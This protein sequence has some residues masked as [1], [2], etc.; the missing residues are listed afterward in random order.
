M[1]LKRKLE[2]MFDKLSANEQQLGHVVSVCILV[3]F[4][5]SHR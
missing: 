4:G 2:R 3:V 5:H 1:T